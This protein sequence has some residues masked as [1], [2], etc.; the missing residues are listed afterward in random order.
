[1]N[2]SAELTTIHE[3]L[4]KITADIMK[5]TL[6]EIVEKLEELESE[7]ETIRRVDLLKEY[8]KLSHL[9]FLSEAI[10]KIEDYRQTVIQFSLSGVSMKNLN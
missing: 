7:P 1:M 6:K 9:I 3:S 5:D 4:V 10:D 2:E 8:K